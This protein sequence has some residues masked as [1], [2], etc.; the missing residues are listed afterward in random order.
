M[1]DVDPTTGLSLKK[2]REAMHLTQRD[3]AEHTGISQPTIARIESGQRRASLAEL[4]VLG[5]ACGVFLNDMLGEGSL[6]DQV[7]CAGRTDS[8]GSQALSEYLV[9]AFTL[10]QRLDQLGVPEVV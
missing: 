10:S 7:Q 5:E 1:T 3:L 9:Y 4:S 2:A 6:A 8:E